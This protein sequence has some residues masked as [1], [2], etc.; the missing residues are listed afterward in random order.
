M[1]VTIRDRRSPQED[2]KRIALHLNML[3]FKYRLGPCCPS[4]DF[5]FD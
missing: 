3:G 2:R 1:Q 5:W 4:K